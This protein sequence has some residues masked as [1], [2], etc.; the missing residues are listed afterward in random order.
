MGLLWWGRLLLNDLMKKNYPLHLERSKKT[1]SH[2]VASE[3]GTTT[4]EPSL[5]EEQYFSSKSHVSAWLGEEIL[6]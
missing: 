5:V 1:P 2:T 3:Q 4:Q 6:P